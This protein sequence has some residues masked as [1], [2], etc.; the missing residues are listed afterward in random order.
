MT[1]LALPAAPALAQTTIDLCATTGTV[2]MPDATVV[3][4]WGYVPGSTCAPGD[5]TLPG[6]VLRPTPGDAVLTVNLTNNL[7]EPVSFLVPGL[8]STAT[9]GV[10]GKFTSEVSP[11][12]TATYTFALRPGTFLYHSATDRI[13]TQVPMGLYGALVVDWAIGQA[14][15]GVSY[16]QDEVLIFSAIDPNLNADPAGFGG[17]RVINW[18]PQYF[19]INGKSHPDTTHIAFTTGADVLLRMVN[20]GLTTVV[21]TLEGGLYAGL[22][23]EDG[24]RYPH[25]MS[26]YGVELPA[27]KTVDAM[28]RVTSEGTYALYDRTLRLTTQG[29]TS[30]GMLTYLDVAGSAGVLE[31]G[32]AALGVAESGATLTVTVNRVGGS[33]GA[34][35]VDY[36]TADGTATAGSDYTA[37]GGTLGFADGETTKTFDLT[38]LDDAATPVF[39]GNET[40]TVSLGNPTGGATLGTPSSAVVTIV[41]DDPAPGVLQ[42]GAATYGVA[43][44]GGILTVTVDRVGGSAGPVAVNYATANGTATAGSDYTAASGTLSFADGVIGQAFPVAILDDLA[45]EGNETFTV[46]LNTPTGGASLGTPSSAVVT[47]SEND[48][49]PNVAPFANDDVAATSRNTAITVNVVANDVDPDGAVDPAT[50]V[51][52]TG[53]LSQF[54]GTVTNNLDG[55]VTFAPRRGFRG[56]DTFQYNVKDDGTPPLT[57][58]TATVRVNVR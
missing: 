16:D 4:I 19:L 44:N 28:V 25:P 13:R 10:A 15:P 23:A 18:I 33:A 56:T 47:I 53:P 14:Y 7:A 26:Q 35:T 3:P 20:A 2:T 46:S 1:V 58:N 48:P 39:E 55:T 38:I 21:P 51:V 6:P 45:Y 52:T 36:A 22:V 41:D 27:A 42:L 29:A 17:A 49:A 11:G 30:G 34:I 31:L 40:F 12:G 37:A 5:A 9:G 24:N 43:E 57:S 54:G 50:V 8:R 32:A